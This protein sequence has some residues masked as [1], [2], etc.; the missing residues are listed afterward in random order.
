MMLRGL[1]IRQVIIGAM[2]TLTVIALACIIALLVTAGSMSREVAAQADRLVHD[3]DAADRIVLHVQLQLAAAERF[4]ISGDEQHLQRFRDEGY[5][6]YDHIRVFLF[7]D[8]GTLE[9]LLV[10]RIRERHQAIEVAAQRLF[11]TG[12]GSEAVADLPGVRELQRD[13]STFVDLRR[14]ETERLLERQH[15]V[16]R[17]L[18]LAC[19]ILGIAFGA[20]LVIAGIFLRRRLL[21]PLNAL[22]QAARRVGAGEFDARVSFGGHDELAAVAASF[23]H[24]AER[25]QQARADAQA[26]EHRFRELIESLTAVVWEADADT[27]R[28]TYVSPQAELMFGH[29]VAAWTE[30]DIWRTIIHPDD[31]DVTMDL[32]AAG[33]AR[34]EDHVVEFRAVR[35][36]GSVVWVRDYVRVLIGESGARRLRGVM[37]DVTE[38]RLAGEARRKSEE[39]YHSLVERVPVG[40][41]RTTPEGRLV[42]A[43]PT[44]AAML[45]YESREQLL[46]MNVLH[47]YADP[48]DR[49]SWKEALDRAGGV[50]EVDRQHR[51]RDGRLV[52]LRDTA[53]AVRDENGAVLYYEGALQD[54]TDR[55]DAEEAVR[56]SEARF[57]SLIENAS[58]GVLILSAEGLIKYQSPAVERILGYAAGETIGR[59]PFDLVHPDDLGDVQESFVNVMTPEGHGKSVEFRCRHRDGTWRMLHIIGTDLRHDPAI[60]GIVVNMIDSTTHRSLEQQLQ[61]SQ[62]LEAVGRLAGGIAHDFNNL[63]TAIR[64]Y[65][66][67]LGDKVRDDNR[68]HADVVE[69][70][71]AVD[72][73][74]RLTRQLLAFSRR[75]VVRPQATDL[76]AVITELERMLRR[77]ITEEIPFRTTVV[78]D[79]WVFADPGQLEQIVVNLVVNARDAHPRTGIDLGV[80]TA[81]LTGVAAAAAGVDPG[82]Y[83]V[84]SIADDGAGIDPE[85]LPHIFEPFFTTKDVGRGTGLGLAT[86]YGIVQD[87][88][89]VVRAES[90]VG[91]GTRL[92]VYLPRIAAPRVTPAEPHVMGEDPDQGTE[93][94]LLVEDE[95][96]VRSLAERILL[97]QGYHVLAA[98]SGVEALALAET[99]HGQIDLLVTDVVMPQMGGVELARRM[100][101][102]RPGLRVLFISGYAADT[103]P[104]EDA[105]GRALHFLEKP[106]SPARFAEIIRGILDEAAQPA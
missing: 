78:R 43:N 7:R 35:A 21:E 66:D 30:T 104:T 16:W 26:A 70:R 63:L 55:V 49:R 95:A 76:G 18:Y 44:L 77:L 56:R 45:G 97:R 102:L 53:R 86:V 42:E 19:G 15:A 96:A 37:T 13:L 74:S 93:L 81:A 87:A 54:V 62:R 58:E 84:L 25:L 8:P 57:R 32:C 27:L 71:R 31:Y 29:S 48:D 17:W 72:R 82:E 10:E 92:I 22:S 106:F 67:L 47:V 52:W 103:V 80:E 5:A 23:N 34:G 85:V 40:L 94:I 100:L 2:A 64:G 46:A 88:G 38:A 68:A 51:R 9:R 69:I 75:Q 101:E 105:G 39:R 41:Y 60:N 90:S 79:A 11:A 3:E 50:I 14:Q 12:R 83:V 65:T 59:S 61:H 89:G 98:A 73:A 99:V 36:D 33:T 4:M 28:C 6:V 91:I 1:S 24:M 20:L